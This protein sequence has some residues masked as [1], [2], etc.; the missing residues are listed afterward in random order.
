MF[1]SLANSYHFLFGITQPVTFY[2]KIHFYLDKLVAK[3]F[4]IT[5]SRKKKLVDC[6][7]QFTIGR[8]NFFHVFLTSW[9]LTFGRKFFIYR[10]FFWYV[11][12]ESLT[13]W[14]CK[15]IT[16]SAYDLSWQPMGNTAELVA[17]QLMCK[18]NVLMNWFGS[19]KRIRKS[20]K[21]A[22]WCICVVYVSA[23]SRSFILHIMNLK[24]WKE[25]S[26]KLL[27]ST[28]TVVQKSIIFLNH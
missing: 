10:Y 6:I 17:H 19:R 15:E 18:W 22:C 3:K 25:M 14:W 11:V 27:T 8:C 4:T 23:K 5:K 28:C 16:F 12:E 9:P 7:C 20:N 2:L 21:H 1:I 26:N 13:S 24:I